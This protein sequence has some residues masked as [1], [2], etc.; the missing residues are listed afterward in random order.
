MNE[1]D[2]KASW[3]RRHAAKRNLSAPSGG[4]DERVGVKI[5]ND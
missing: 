5:E 4:R 2:L 1:V 3:L